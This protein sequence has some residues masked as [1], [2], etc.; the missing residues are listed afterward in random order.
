MKRN[1]D[2]FQKDKQ[3]RGIVKITRIL[4]DYRES[5]KQMLQTNTGMSTASA[6]AAVG[7]SKNI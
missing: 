6:L 3:Y 2:E 7:I 1:Q 4:A 5:L